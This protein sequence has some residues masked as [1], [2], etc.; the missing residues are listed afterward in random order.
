MSSYTSRA[1]GRRRS[2][3]SRP[4]LVVRARAVSTKLAKE[5]ADVLDCS[6]KL[7][8]E[9]GSSYAAEASERSSRP[10]DSEGDSRP[11]MGTACTARTPSI[12]SPHSDRRWSSALTR[13]SRRR[14]VVCSVARA[15]HAQ[16]RKPASG[17]PTCRSLSRTAR[18]PH[19]RCRRKRPAA[20]WTGRSR[21]RTRT[22]SGARTR[23][24]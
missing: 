21:R 17:T 4:S 1:T 2:A 20:R 24:A 15:G 23:P 5:N 7:C 22:G 19:R 11:R 14:P 13:A 9:E 12:T 8:E 6:W 18:R 3:T 10:P 16:T